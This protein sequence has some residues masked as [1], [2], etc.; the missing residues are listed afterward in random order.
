VFYFNQKGVNMQDQDQ[1]IHDPVFTVRHSQVI[2]PDT[3]PRTDHRFAVLTEAE[4]QLQRKINAMYINTLEEDIEDLLNNARVFKRSS[5]ATAAFYYKEVQ[6]A[7]TRLK[8]AAEL[9]HSMKHCVMSAPD[10]TNAFIQSGVILVD[11]NA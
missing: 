4:V 2:R 11:T 6:K 9:Q 10:M 3:Q 5:P 7:R 1:P 8:K